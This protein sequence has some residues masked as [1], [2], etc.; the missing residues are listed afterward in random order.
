MD[1]GNNPTD[2]EKRSENSWAAPVAR[3][4]VAEMPAG[5]LNLN[6]QGRQLSGLVRG[7]GQMWQKTYKIR[8]EGT[9]VT[10]SQVIETWKKNF[11]SF[12][13]KGYRF[14][15]RP[16]GI[17]PGDVA[18]LNLSPGGLNVPGGL[19][20]VSTGIMVIYAD[21][22]SFSFMTPQG[23]MFAGM[24]TF[25]SYDDHGTV[26]QVQALVRAS[27][28]L[29]EVVFRLGG[30]KP[31]AR[32]SVTAAGRPKSGTIGG[33]E[34]FNKTGIRRVFMRGSPPQRPITRAT[35]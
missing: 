8:L 30:T 7:F 15:G 9:D 17:A 22:E 28:P 10:P 5:A 6:V 27:D 21:E 20:L 13:P 19:P 1:S 25:S 18:V 26:A 11:S 29:I 3:L 14:Y 12:W 24:I 16:A 23:H 4:E 35:P 32:A 34:A 2:T 33:Q 31:A